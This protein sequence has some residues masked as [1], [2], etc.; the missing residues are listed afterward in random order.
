MIALCFVSSSKPQSLHTGNPYADAALYWGVGNVFNYWGHHAGKYT[1][2]DYLHQYGDVLVPI[3]LNIK[4]LINAV[5]REFFGNYLKWLPEAPLNDIPGALKTLPGNQG[6]MRSRAWDAGRNFYTSYECGAQLV[7][8][9]YLWRAIREEA[10]QAALQK[11]Q[12]KNQDGAE[13]AV[14]GAP[15]FTFEDARILSIAALYFVVSNRLTHWLA[16]HF[17][18]ATTDMLARKIHWTTPYTLPKPGM[19]STSEMSEVS[20]PGAETRAISVFKIDPYM[21]FLEATMCTWITQVA[22]PRIRS[23]MKSFLEMFN[24]YDEK[25]DKLFELAYKIGD[26]S[27]WAYYSA[28]AHV[29]AVQ[30]FRKDP[31]EAVHP[32]S[33]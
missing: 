32:K 21:N 24:L 27:V 26:K 10:H 3:R 5:A 29:I 19:P 25:Y 16:M 2:A 1:G 12:A 14:D 13:V 18:T 31:R 6:T 22:N 8:A 9:W 30:Q 7:E 33:E 28:R 17:A 20:K 15:V 11:E 4:Y 23:Y